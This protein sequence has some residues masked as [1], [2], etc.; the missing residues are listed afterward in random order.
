L[1]I[2]F[3]LRTSL[4]WPPEKRA[5][6]AHH[7]GVEETAAAEPL[8]GI[9][10]ASKAQYF[11]QM[12]QPSQSDSKST[13]NQLSA[14]PGLTTIFDFEGLNALSVVV[15]NE[16]AREQSIQPE[17]FSAFMTIRSAPAMTPSF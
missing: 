5:S 7:A 13:V 9:A 17:Q 4:A 8:C 15:K 10:R 11:T 14:P 2:V 12:P 1:S 6:R 3:S 16:H